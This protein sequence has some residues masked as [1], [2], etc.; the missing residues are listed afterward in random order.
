MVKS[1]KTIKVIMSSRE[2]K[3]LSQSQK[4]VAIDLMSSDLCIHSVFDAS[5]TQQHII[6]YQINHSSIK[7]ISLEERDNHNHVFLK[8][9]KIELIGDF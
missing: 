4:K 8:K 1:G 9:K 7:G 2:D 5:L 3:R 6:N